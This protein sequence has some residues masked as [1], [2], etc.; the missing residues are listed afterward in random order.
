MIPSE[1]MIENTKFGG[2]I[3]TD[4]DGSIDI[5]TDEENLYRIDYSDVLKPKMGS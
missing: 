4:P 2:S 3:I 5:V 1:N